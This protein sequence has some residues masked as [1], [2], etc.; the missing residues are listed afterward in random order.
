MTSFGQRLKML[1][2]EADLSQAELA[3]ALGVS[4]HSVSKWECDS[5]MPDVSLLLP[6]ST[7]LCVTTDCL[8]GAG[9]NEKDD[10][11]NLE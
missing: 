11:K 5:N 8:L 2:R 9:M 1:R 6:L 10:L 3:E 4:V 7:V